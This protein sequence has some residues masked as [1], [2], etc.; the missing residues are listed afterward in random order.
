MVPSLCER[1]G[2][3]HPSYELTKVTENA[4]LYSGYAH[5]GGDPRIDGPVGEVTAVYGQKN[6]KEAIAEELVRFL[7]SIEKHRL[8][9]L[10]VD[11]RK[12]KREEG[13]ENAEEDFIKV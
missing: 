12:R 11:E 4:S 13:E 10:E 7:R 9:Q 1:L 2:F 3:Q 5:F 6:A 8:E